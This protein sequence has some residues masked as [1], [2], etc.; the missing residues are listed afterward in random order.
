MDGITKQ[1][2]ALDALLDEIEQ[3]AKSLLAVESAGDLNTKTPLTSKYAYQT[4]VIQSRFHQFAK[5][6]RVSA[7]REFRFSFAVRNC[8]CTK[9]QHGHVPGQLFE[10]RYMLFPEMQIVCRQFFNAARQQPQKWPQRKSRSEQ[11]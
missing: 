7:S 8:P 3:D 10:K 6:P 2:D 5:K 4:P 9:P 11:V 1:I